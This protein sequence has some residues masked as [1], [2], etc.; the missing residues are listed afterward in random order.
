MQR[1]G[2]TEFSASLQ[3]GLR[4]NKRS[5]AFVCKNPLARVKERFR[6]FMVSD[7]FQDG[8]CLPLF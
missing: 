8:R 3:R 2:L 4:V 7:P 5:F 6:D 1:I